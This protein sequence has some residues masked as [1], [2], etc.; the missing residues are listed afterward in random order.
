MALADDIEA[1]RQRTLLALDASH[2]YYTFTKRAWRLMRQVVR[3]GREFSFW[4]PATGTRLDQQG[5]VRRGRIYVADNLIVS[6]FQQF[7]S[8]LEEFFFGLLRCWLTAFPGSLLKKQVELSFVLNAPD[9]AA[10]LSMVI[11][12]E[13]NEWKYERLAEWFARL[14]R[15]VNLGCPT[16]D[17]IEN[18]AEI[19]AARDVLVHN[20]GIANAI[21]IAKA[22]RCARA[23]DGD[24]LEFP[25]QYHRDSWRIIRKVVEELST[26]AIAKAR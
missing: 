22:G 13:L 24:E 11:D 15:L 9:K 2:D 5:L 16:A 17:E 6:T 7:V 10:V 20:N 1:L 19:K 18:L 8:L 21:Y 26:A 25:E 12:R 3:E 4:N 23:R 14:Q